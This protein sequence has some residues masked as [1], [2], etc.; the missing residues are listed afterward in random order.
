MPAVPALP[1]S[2]K[3]LRNARFEKIRNGWSFLSTGRSWN[4]RPLASLWQGWRGLLVRGTG[5][6]AAPVPAERQLR[7]LL[8][9]PASVPRARAQTAT[10]DVR[11]RPAGGPRDCPGQTDRFNMRLRDHHTRRYRVRRAGRDVPERLLQAATSRSWPFNYSSFLKRPQR[12]RAA[13]QRSFLTGGRAGP[14]RGGA[15]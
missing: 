8:P 5:D 1:P 7:A 10:G 12:L 2:P 6:R 15:W 13:R 11:V 4:S 9:A 14:V 3:R